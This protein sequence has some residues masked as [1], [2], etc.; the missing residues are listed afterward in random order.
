VNT[1]ESLGGIYI[2]MPKCEIVAHQC[3][4]RNGDGFVTAAGL[5]FSQAGNETVWGSREYVVF[6]T[7]RKRWFQRVIEHR[8]LYG[9]VQH[10]AAT[11][12]SVVPLIVVHN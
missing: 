12:G 4:C 8:F 2:T 7:R 6:C 5:F 9:I 11:I 3:C 10:R 1:Y